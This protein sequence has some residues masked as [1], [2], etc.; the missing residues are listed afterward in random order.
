MGA[1]TGVTRVG[2]EAE[3]EMMTDA[4]HVVLET[5]HWMTHA[6][7]VISIEAADVIAR[8]QDL[9]IGIIDHEV[10]DV[11]EMIVTIGTIG[12]AASHEILVGQER[13]NA[14]KAEVQSQR[15]RVPHL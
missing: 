4:T 3:V 8:D 1:R 11:S 6:V 15:K 9:L 10:T 7:T 14:A 12:R 13:R 2:E 5:V